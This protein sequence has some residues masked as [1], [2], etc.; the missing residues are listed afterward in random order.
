[1]RN[2]CLSV[3]HSISTYN[4]RSLESV[5]SRERNLI[6]FNIPENAE[7]SPQ[8]RS[9]HDCETVTTIIEKLLVDSDQP[10][11]I[12]QLYRRGAY[13]PSGRPRPLKLIM[14]SSD[15]AQLAIKCRYRLEGTPFS[16]RP[17]LSY[18][19]HLR[20]REAVQELKRQT[21]DGEKD[22]IIVNFRVVPRRRLVQQPLLISRTH[23]LSSP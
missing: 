9:Y 12:S 23:A 16:I 21:N 4:S 18:D 7:D 5:N 13:P 10:V 17:D 19:D 15:A 6:I 1:M 11:A 8:S 20:R 14:D 22:L 2:G 3:A